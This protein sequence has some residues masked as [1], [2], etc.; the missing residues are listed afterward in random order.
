MLMRLMFISVQKFMIYNENLIWVISQNVI[1]HRHDR[2]PP[3][4]ILPYQPVYN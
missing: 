2:L 4:Y 3:N 1:V